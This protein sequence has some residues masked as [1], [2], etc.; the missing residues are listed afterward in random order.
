LALAFFF[1]IKALAT[2][3]WLEAGANAST[4]NL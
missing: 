1:G 3:R 2:K 4:G